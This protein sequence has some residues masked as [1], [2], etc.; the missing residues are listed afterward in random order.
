[1]MAFGVRLVFLALVFAASPA[2]SE[3]IKNAAYRFTLN[4]PDGWHTVSAGTVA[5]M[6]E[7]VG[8]QSRAN[9]AQTGRATLVA[10]SKYKEP[11]K[12]L[13]SSFMMFGA[14]VGPAVQSVPPTRFMDGAVANA[15]KT[16]GSA[17]SIASP[18]KATTVGGLPAAH[19]R[20]HLDA[21]VG[22]KLFKSETDIWIVPHGESLLF[23]Q[24]QA[25][26]GDKAAG[27]AT[28]RAAVQSIRFER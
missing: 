21:P 13:N 9:I 23:I 1:M 4:K 15:L 12:E 11:T 16:G 20:F 19:A 6:A 26:R 5:A 14:K 17:I 18:T 22:G 27:M 3:T 25:K 7:P 10:F 24:I 8:S 2:Y 28:L